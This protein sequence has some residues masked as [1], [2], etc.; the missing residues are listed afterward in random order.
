[1]KAVAWSVNP[2]YRQEGWLQHHAMWH[3]IYY[4]L[5]FH[6]DYAERYG[7]Y[8]D[9]QG[10][11]AMPMAAALR[12][13]KEHPEEDKPDIYLAPKALKMS[14]MERLDRLAFFEF[15]RRDPLFTF[16]TFFMVKGKLI[17]EYIAGQSRVEWNRAPWAV[18]LLFIAVIM[19]TGGLAAC[20]STGM[21]RLSRLA[22]VSSAGALASLLIP[23]LTVVFVQVMSEEIMAIQLAAFLLLSLAF[24]GIVRTGMRHY[25]TR[26]YR[27]AMAAAG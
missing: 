20:S 6:P 18:R 15:A 17:A 1:M 12:Y 14:A 27:D 22:A 21:Q 10:G 8:H 3:S 24:A 7:A 5:Q 11:D 13:V 19:L 9:G 25:A 23:F 4:S 26:S 16:Q 2:I